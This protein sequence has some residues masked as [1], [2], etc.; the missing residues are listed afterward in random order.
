MIAIIRIAGDVEIDEKD[1]EKLFRLRLRKKYTCI[2][3]KESKEMGILINKIRNFVAY[4]KIDSATLKE[5]VEKRGKSIDSKKK[6]DS[7]KVIELIEKKGLAESGIKPFFRLH[8]PRGGID[9]KIHYP[10]GV[11]GDNKEDINELIRR[12]L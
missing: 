5:L 10:K 6:V 11:L 2:V 9:S 1:R 7:A 8:P 4:G 3:I 12:M